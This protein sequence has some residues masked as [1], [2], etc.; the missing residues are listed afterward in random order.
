MTEETSTTSGIATPDNT[1]SFS[2]RTYHG[3]F[4]SDDRELLRLTD[5]W[6]EVALR[7]HAKKCPKRTT[8]LN[9]ESNDGACDTAR[10]YRSEFR[11][12]THHKCDDSSD[13]D[14]QLCSDAQRGVDQ[15]STGELALDDILRLG[16]EQSERLERAQ[17]L[18]NELI[19][20]KAS[21]SADH[22]ST[23]SRTLSWRDREKPSPALARTT[24]TTSEKAILPVGAQK[25]AVP[26]PGKT[27]LLTDAEHEHA[28]T[29]QNGQ[30]K[31]VNLATVQ[32]FPKKGGC[33]FWNC[34]EK[35]GWLGFQNTASGTFLGR[36]GNGSLMAVVKHH[37]N[38]EWFCVRH[39][40]GG[41]YLLLMLDWDKL[42]KVGV[43]GE[44]ERSS[45]RW[46]TEGE[47]MKWGFVQV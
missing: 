41:G 36:D 6:V 10:D 31:F 26:R 13:D 8:A 29:L 19:S 39:L 22:V 4:D 38:H 5:A 7:R 43:Q 27:F 16:R 15:N 44:G 47:G 23:P 28:L 18:L 21:D 24:T 9:D 11:G 45:F 46:A 34:V 37:K 17:S 35:N 33:Y 30:L 32:K 12:F 40:E 2:D 14:E 25:G 42:V 3:L 1:D 20:D